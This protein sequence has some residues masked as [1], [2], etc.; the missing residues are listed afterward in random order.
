M[1]TGQIP[2]NIRTSFCQKEFDRDAAIVLAGHQLEK[3]QV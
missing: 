1:Q 3:E 2:P